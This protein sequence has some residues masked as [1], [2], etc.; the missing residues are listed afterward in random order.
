MYTD[1]CAIC[2]RIDELCEMDDLC[3]NCR[4]IWCGTCPFKKECSEYTPYP[5]EEFYNYGEYYERY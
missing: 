3:Y 2:N 4:I 1:N 5:S